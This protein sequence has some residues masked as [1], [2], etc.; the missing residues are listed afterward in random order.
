MLLYFSFGPKKW[1]LGA[2]FLLN[3]RGIPKEEEEEE[4]EEEEDIDDDAETV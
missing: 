1:T 4:E 3:R 2:S